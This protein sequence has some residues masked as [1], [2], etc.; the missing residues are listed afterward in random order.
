MANPFSIEQ[1]LKAQDDESQHHEK[2]QVTLGDWVGPYDVL[3]QV[4]QDQ[5]LNLLDLNISVLLDHYLEYIEKMPEMDINE[6]SE[7]LVVAASLA[8]IK[9]KLLLPKDEVEEEEQEEDPRQQLVD[10][11]LEYQK[12]KKVAQ[13]LRERPLLGRDVFVKGGRESFPA[14]EAEGHGKLFQLVKGFQ[15]AIE[16]AGN[17]K[18]FEISVEEVSVADRFHEIFRLVSVE[19]EVLFDD[20]LPAGSSKVYLIASF[21]AVLEMIRM[22]K[23]RVLQR[24]QGERIFIVYKEGATDDDV[25]HSE[26]D[27][28]P[29]ESEEPTEGAEAQT[30]EVV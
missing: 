22:K 15:K 20:L 10:Y 26:F 2:Y 8:Q 6:A 24:D 5:E 28:P 3:L 18:E 11:L 27:A 12:I 25:V 4:I 23:A 7:F 21:L 14:I 30:S 13:E 16:R 19:K 17:Q 29:S 9:S 1:L